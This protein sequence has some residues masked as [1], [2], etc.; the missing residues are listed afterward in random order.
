MF[1]G[2]TPFDDTIEYAIFQKISNEDFKM[3]LNAPY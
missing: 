3:P 2:K 1:T